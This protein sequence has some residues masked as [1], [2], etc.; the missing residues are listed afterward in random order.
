M[1]VTPTEWLVACNLISVAGGLTLFGGTEKSQGFGE[2][3]ALVVVL[4]L[5]PEG[6]GVVG[7]WSCWMLVVLRKCPNFIKSPNYWGYNLQQKV[8]RWC[9]KMTKIPKKGHLPTP[10]SG[11]RCVFFGNS[12]DQS[13][14]HRQRCV[15]GNGCREL[16]FLQ[17]LENEGSLWIS[18]WKIVEDRWRL[19]LL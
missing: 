17:V 2:S 4:W 3:K 16:I 19:Y 5:L 14:K 18:V 11:L 9:L 12:A 15:D 7:C 8:W 10:V 6:A 13:R 1:L